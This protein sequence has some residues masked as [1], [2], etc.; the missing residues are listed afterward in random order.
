LSEHVPSARG[1]EAGAGAGVANKE[2]GEYVGAAA[3]F[4]GAGV[5]NKE[6]GEYVGAAAAF[7]A[8]DIGVANMEP[9]TGGGGRGPEGGEPKG[10]GG[11]E[12]GE[13]KG[14]GGGS[15]LTAAVAGAP[16]K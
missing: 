5:A 7:V 15:G 2:A 14:R 10:R 6:A 13:P 1:G 3:A 11:P 4:I 12:G 16:K 8:A 9:G